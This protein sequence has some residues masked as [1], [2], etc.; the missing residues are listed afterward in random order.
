MPVNN[1]AVNVNAVN[2]AY[3]SFASVLD[4][5]SFNDYGLQNSSIITPVEWF[6]LRDIASREINL[7]SK[8]QS[9]W[10]ILNPCP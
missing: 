10:M 7:F 6:W 5:L 1:N 4:S 8:P 2:Q 9:N 3:I